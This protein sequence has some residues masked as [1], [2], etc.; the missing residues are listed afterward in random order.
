MPETVLGLDPDL[1]AALARL[2]DR[3]RELLALRFG[4]DLNGPEIA[5]LT[6][7]SLANVQQIL[8]RTLRRLR[9]ELE[10]AGRQAGVDQPTSNQ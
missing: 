2:D 8:S 9:H 10:P 1:E 6:G 4:G 7:L 3:E 5:G